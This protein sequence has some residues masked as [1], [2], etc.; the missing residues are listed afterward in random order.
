[1]PCLL[2]TLISCVMHAH[3]ALPVAT[4]I[5]TKEVLELLERQPGVARQVGLHLMG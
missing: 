2:A 4:A 3:V 5:V 1:M